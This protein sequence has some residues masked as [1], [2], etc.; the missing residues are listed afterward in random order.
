MVRKDLKDPV[1]TVM[2]VTIEPGGASGGV[3]GGGNDGAWTPGDALNDAVRVLEV[4][5]GVA[6]VGVAV[7][8]P[9]ALLGLR[10]GFAA[11]G[12]RRRRREQALEAG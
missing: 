1:L 12:A 10:A 5:A 11:R 7:L 2:G 9:F 8:A 3:G 4:F 6:V